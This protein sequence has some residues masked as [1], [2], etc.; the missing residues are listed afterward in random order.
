MGRSGIL[1]AALAR[2]HP[3]WGTPYVATTVVFALCALGLL[4]PLN[5]VFLFLAVNI[6]TLLKYA[7]TSF[8]ATRVVSRH[9]EIYQAAPFKLGPRAMHG[10]AWASVICALVVIVLGLGADWRPYVTLLGWG[11]LGLVYYAVRS[12]NQEVR[13]VEDTS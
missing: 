6:P 4:M 11:T 7:A 10:W 8:A 2:V 9:R 13:S 12:R 5:L 3:R 1:P